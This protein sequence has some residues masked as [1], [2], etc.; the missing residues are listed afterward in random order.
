[1][2]KITAGVRDVYRAT[3]DPTALEILRGMA[4]WVASATPSPGLI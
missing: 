4:S 2:H 3:G 1:M